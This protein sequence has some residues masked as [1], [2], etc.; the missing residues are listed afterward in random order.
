LITEIRSGDNPAFYRYP[1]RDKITEPRR[2]RPRR[3]QGCVRATSGRTTEA[4][5]VDQGAPRCSQA[6]RSQARRS[7]A[8]RSQATARGPPLAGGSVRQVAADLL[9][10]VATIGSDDARLQPLRPQLILLRAGALERVDGDD[11]AELGRAFQ[12]KP[13]RDG[14]QEP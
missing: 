1:K 7:Q 2:V 14:G 8:R 13:P 12:A 6:R 9:G 3:K 4:T 5:P 10:G 11:V